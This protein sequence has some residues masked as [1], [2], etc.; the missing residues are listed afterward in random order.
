[1]SKLSM[2]KK[3]LAKFESR[4][5]KLERN[6]LGNLP[7]GKEWQLQGWLAA[8]ELL[9]APLEVSRGIHVPTPRNGGV[10]RSHL[11]RFSPIPERRITERR[12]GS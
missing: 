11:S 3:Q 12:K 5:G 9:V 7:S 6:G 1:M 4:F 8:I 10:R 2:T